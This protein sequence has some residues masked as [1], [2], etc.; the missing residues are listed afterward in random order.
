MNTEWKY[1]GDIN[2]EY[3]GYYYRYDVNDKG[4][5]YY[6]EIVRITDLDSATGANGLTLIEKL[7][8]FDYSNKKK[9]KDSLSCIGL[10]TNDFKGHKP[11]DILDTI[12]DAFLSYGYYDPLEDYITPSQIII[13]NDD[14]DAY[15][16]KSSWDGWKP[17]IDET[18]K[19]HHIYNGNLKDY[20]ESEY[21]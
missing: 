5:P 8:T 4:F 9:I 17:D 21:L 7:T 11:S 15:S 10:T 20:I 16:N 3:G 12:T 2:L 6:A 14:Y 13:V 18:V 1:I 19:L